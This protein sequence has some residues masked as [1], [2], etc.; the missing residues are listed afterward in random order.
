ME[1][2]GQILCRTKPIIGWVTYRVQLSRFAEFFNRRP[3]PFIINHFLKLI[4]ISA[5]VPDESLDDVIAEATDVA[6]QEAPSP[7]DRRPLPEGLARFNGYVV[8]TIPAAEWAA[9]PRPSRSP[10]PGRRL[11]LQY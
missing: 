10:S 11:A 8:E 2:D 5:A 9:R 1:R 6:R 4:T 3:V 7:F